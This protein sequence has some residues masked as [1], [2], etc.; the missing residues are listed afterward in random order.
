MVEATIVP[1]DDEDRYPLRVDDDPDLTCS[2]TLHVEL[3]APAGVTLRLELLDGDDVVEETT[4]ADATPGRIS[5]S[6]PRCFVD[7]AREYEVVVTPVGSDRTAE[8]YVLTRDGG[9]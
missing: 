4:S 5:V 9:F 1:A 3:T 8:P 2:G 7:D 6:E